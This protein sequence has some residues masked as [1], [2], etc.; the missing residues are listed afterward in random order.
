MAPFTFSLAVYSGIYFATGIFLLFTGLRRQGIK[1][2]RFAVTL[3]TKA[4]S[5]LALAG[6]PMYGLTP[7]PQYLVVDRR[8]ACPRDTLS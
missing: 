4:C 1:M 2:V 7:Q 3:F 6:L 8:V 5:G